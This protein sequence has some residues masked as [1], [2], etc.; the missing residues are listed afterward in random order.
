MEQQPHANCIAFMNRTRQ[1][2]D[3]KPTFDGRIGIPGSVTEHR[4][5]LWA[6]ECARPKASAMEIMFNGQI[7]AVTPGDAPLQQVA[8]DQVRGRRG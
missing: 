3:N 5:A 8:A 7:D 4:F 6:H 1:P 2:G